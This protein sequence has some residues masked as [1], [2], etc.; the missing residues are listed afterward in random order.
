MDFEGRL[1]AYTS[2]IERVLRRYLN[3]EQ[4]LPYRTV[5][6]A[7]DYSLSAGGKRIRPILTL[8]FCR[9]CGG[10]AEDAYPFAAAIEMVHTYSLIHDDLPCMDD[11]DYRRGRPT[12]HK[13]Y[14]EAMAVLAGDGLLTEAFAT[15]LSAEIPAE[16]TVRAAAE[17]A[18]A[19]G[20][21]GMLG[22]QVIDLESENRQIP[23]ALLETLHRQKTAALIRGAV[24]MGAIVGGAD[25]R[26]LEAAD[27][28]AEAL[29]LA[30]QITDDIL[31]VTGDA[32]KLGKSVH[33]DER[34]GKSTYVTALGLEAAK[35]RAEELT[36]RAIDSLGVFSGADFLIWLSG[37][38]L[39][40]EN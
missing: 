21:S 38:L 14:G 32:E 6:E 16:R 39:G 5:L 40:R 27:C 34:A 18:R 4:N 29:G 19:A 25:E 20:C 12:N 35:K 17:L 13:M 2:E 26:Q 24:R 23:L 7:M 22:G 28:Y 30:F 1:K 15:A 9:L 33:S 11:D 10:A 37:K 31:D 8:E 36:A 3:P